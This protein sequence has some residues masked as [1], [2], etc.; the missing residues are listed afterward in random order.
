MPPLCEERLRNGDQGYV[1]FEIPLCRASSK[2]EP[3]LGGRRLWLPGMD[4]PYRGTS[5][6]RKRIP[7][8]PYRR[9]MSRVL[10]GVLGGFAFS[11]GRGTPVP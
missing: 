11:Y 7:L 6:I 5:L 8:G 1:L 3:S 9:P 10:K 4:L 2:D